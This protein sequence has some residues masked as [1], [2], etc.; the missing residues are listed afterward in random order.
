ME[1]FGGVTALPL[2]AALESHDKLL[3][4]RLGSLVPIEDPFVARN[5]AGWRGG[6]L[7]HVPARGKLTEPIKVELPLDENGSGVYW[8][9]PIVLEEGAQAGG[10]GDCFSA[11]D[12]T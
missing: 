6:V 1:G 3:H 12:R 2:G 11:G 4:E 8:R 7:V 9:T 10:W 5:E